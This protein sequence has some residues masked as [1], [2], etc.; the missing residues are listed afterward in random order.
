[1]GG[2]LFDGAIAGADGELVEIALEG[3]DGGG[4]V[5]YGFVVEV[6]EFAA[7][8]GAGIVGCGALE[9][10]CGEG[11]WVAVEAADFSFRWRR[12]GEVGPIWFVPDFSGR[13]LFSCGRVGCIG[14]FHGIYDAIQETP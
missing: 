14:I 10:G 4:A 8:A 11:V 12:W 3:V 13:R 2:L 5:F 1:M 6:E 9:N 7:L